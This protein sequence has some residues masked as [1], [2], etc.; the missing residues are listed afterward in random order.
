M[1]KSTMPEP[2][3]RQRQI[4]MIKIPTELVMSAGGTRAVESLLT[5]G[6]YAGTLVWERDGTF[7]AQFLSDQAHLDVQYPLIGYI[8]EKLAQ[9]AEQ[10]AA[11]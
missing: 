9:Q 6:P 4:L 8:R 11:E 5:D 7:A 2:P 10:Q 1:P 3:P